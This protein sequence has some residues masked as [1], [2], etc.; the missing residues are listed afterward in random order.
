MYFEHT[1]VNPFV[2]TEDDALSTFAVDVD[3]ASWTLARNYLS[4]AACCRPRTRSGSRSSS[5]PSTPAGRAQHRRRLPHPHR[6]RRLAASASG[7]HLL[8]V[9]VVGTTVDDSEP[10]AGQPDLRHRH[11]RFHEPREPAGRGQEER[12]TSCWTSWAKATA[13]A[14]GLRLAGRGAPRT[15]GH[16]PARRIAAGHRRPGSPAAA[17]TPY[18]GLE[19]AYGHGPQALRRRPRSTA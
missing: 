10:Q 6:R 18:E 15:H 8:R 5:T 3:N 7:Y 2:A 12:C 1:G 19:L 16:Q 9:G 13:W 4:A 17:P 14:R 11:L